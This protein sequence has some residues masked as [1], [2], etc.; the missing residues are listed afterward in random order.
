MQFQE[1][2][3]HVEPSFLP[4]SIQMAK[5]ASAVRWWTDPWAPGT[6]RSQY[7]FPQGWLCYLCWF[8]GFCF[9]KILHLYHLYPEAM[10]GVASPEWLQEGTRGISDSFWQHLGKVVLLIPMFV[11]GSKSKKAA[12]PQQRST[13]QATKPELHPNNSNNSKRCSAKIEEI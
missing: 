3:Q 2:S 12:L 10:G 11:L 1:D 5:E 7:E 13:R 8:L 6:N 9:S 4:C